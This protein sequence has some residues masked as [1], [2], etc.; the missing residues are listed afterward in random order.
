MEH[1]P[2]TDLPLGL[3]E[4]KKAKTRAAIQEHALRLFREQGYSQTTVEQIAAAAE[5]SP[6]TFFRYFP[7][8][9]DV[10]LF[11]ATDPLIMDRL[12]GEPPEVGAIE[13]LRRAMH[14]VY[15]GFTPEEMAR[16]MERQRLVTG[17]PEL[18]AR[19]LSQFADAMGYLNDV[20]AT[21]M[22]RRPDDPA[23]RVFCGALVGT[24]IGQYLA[25][26]G[27]DFRDMLTHIDDALTLLQEG[28]GRL[29][30]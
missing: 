30:A 2:P 20:L 26:G 25:F 27:A 1:P 5:V 23:V 19:A 16:E 15:D 22:G 6:S 9:E 21:R 11:D 8:K 18:R 17:V 12:A 29:D 14:A 7:T 24:I 3:R 28:F 4:R 13:A 10:V